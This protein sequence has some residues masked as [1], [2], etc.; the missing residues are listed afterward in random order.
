MAYFLFRVAI[1][2]DASEYRDIGG[3]LDYISQLTMGMPLLAVVGLGLLLYGIFMF[4]KARYP[5][6]V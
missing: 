2:A 4:V 5:R 1:Q 3:A 6:L